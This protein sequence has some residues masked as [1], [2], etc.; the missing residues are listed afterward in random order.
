MVFVLHPPIL[1]YAVTSSP[2]YAKKYGAEEVILGAAV[3]LSPNARDR[4]TCSSPRLNDGHLN[5]VAV[6]SKFRTVKFGSN[7]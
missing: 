5:L 6:E 7:N 4:T 1:C 3:R 2:R